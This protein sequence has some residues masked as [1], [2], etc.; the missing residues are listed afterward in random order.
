MA[1]P[2]SAPRP[3]SPRPEGG[4][5]RREPDVAP[6]PAARTPPD[7]I[8]EVDE[9]SIE[10]FPASDPPAWTPLAAGAPD[11]D[12]E[13]EPPPPPDGDEPSPQTEP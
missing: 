2:D 7:V 12:A 11:H 5:P 9:A 4:P 1:E 8:D 6:A 3:D 10:S 13:P